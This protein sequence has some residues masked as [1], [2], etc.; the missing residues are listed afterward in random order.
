MTNKESQ[1]F[2]SRDAVFW[3]ENAMVGGVRAMND[4]RSAEALRKTAKEGGGIRGATK[5]QKRRL[6][7]SLHFKL[8][9]MRASRCKLGVKTYTAMIMLTGQLGYPVEAD[10]YF[11][12]MKEEMVYPDAQTY[13]AVMRC[14]VDSPNKV[15]ELWSDMKESSVSPTTM[16]CNS[17]LQCF[18]TN[19]SHRQVTSMELA[20]ETDNIKKNI[21]TY[22]LLLLTAPNLNRVKRLLT[23]M[24]N[25]SISPNTMCLNS[26]IKGC[27]Q[28]YRDAETIFGLMTEQMTATSDIDS[29][30]TLI[31][32]Y[33]KGNNPKRAIDI[34][35]SIP[36]DLSSY[37][38][39]Q[40]IACCVSMTATETDHYFRLA[41]AL[42]C[43]SQRRNVVTDRTFIAVFDIYKKLNL[44]KKMESLFLTREFSPK[45]S[46]SFLSDIS[47]FHKKNG[48][49]PEAQ[50]RSAMKKYAV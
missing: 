9:A 11:N 17:M 8:S 46:F 36:H 18:A 44:I 30:N 47:D 4:S 26:A 45:I 41:E 19:G 49:V 5:S 33:R 31:S 28:R 40:L 16:V 35:E 23:N 50:L 2:W 48:T 7:R 6:M 13:A 39:N 29:Y 1:K 42:F 34:L 27:D 38:V 20:M 24:T 10:K 21:Y 14:H 25:E 12:N 15:K 3:A 37:T 43:E 22:G 32:C